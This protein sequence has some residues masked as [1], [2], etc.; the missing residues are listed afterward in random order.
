V[1]A[2]TNGLSKAVNLLE[3]AFGIRQ[4]RPATPRAAITPYSLVSEGL[5]LPQQDKTAGIENS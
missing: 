5:D 3:Q 2:E 1:I 4:P